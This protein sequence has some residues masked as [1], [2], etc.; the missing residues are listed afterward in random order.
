MK[1]ILILFAILCSIC[2]ATAQT[3]ART[4]FVAAPD[5][6]LPYLPQSTRLDLIDYF[7]SGIKKQ[8]PNRIGEDAGLILA[9]DDELWVDTAEGVR[10]EFYVLRSAKEEYIMLIRTLE[11]PMPFSTVRF[12]THNWQ[13][14]PTSKFI[15][16]PDESDWLAGAG[17]ELRDEFRNNV[18]FFLDD[19]SYYVDSSTL[20][21]RPSID[22]SAVLEYG[23]KLKAVMPERI[24]Y[25]WNG[26]KFVRE[27]H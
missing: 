27:K 24:N 1:N 11:T 2:T 7:D 9:G 18:G 6:V 13:Q 8:M 12:Y 22:K 5:S 21:F 23:D 25:R 19:I 15:A 14:L 4:A 17:K 20:T 26:K 3:T 16:L 10:Y